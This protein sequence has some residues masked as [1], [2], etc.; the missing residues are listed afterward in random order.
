M[1]LKP[2]LQLVLLLAVAA[3]AAIAYYRYRPDVGRLVGLR[4][5]PASALAER[6]KAEFVHAWNGF[7]AH[8]WGHDELAPLSLAPR[9]WHDVPLLMTEVDSLDALLMLGL[10]EEAARTKTHILTALSFDEDIT[11]KVFEITIRLLGG[12]LSAHQMTGDPKLLALA[13]DLGNRLLPAFDSPTGMPYRFV[14]LKTGE[15]SGAETNPAEVGTLL[16]EFGTLGRLTGRDEFY[17]R[18]KQALV[19]LYDRRSPAT[20][21]VG[22]WISVESGEYTGTTSHVG[23]GIDSYYEYLLKCERL[24]GDADCGRMWK[25]GVAAVNRYLADEVD[26]GLWYGE[27]DMTT[28]ARTATTY[29]ALHAFF[30][31]VLA[32]G[33]DLERARRLQESGFRMW[34]LTGVEPEELDYSTMTITSESYQLRPELVESA[35]YLFH[36][37][38]DPRYQEM[39]RTVLDGLIARCRTESGYTTLRSVKTWEKGDRMHSFL[40]TETFKYLYLLFDPSAV[41][42]EAVVFNT[43]AHPL[44]R[45]W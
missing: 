38:K 6:T 22:D 28:G 10:D 27:A 45:T 16:L 23:G 25:D 18:A 9:D 26:G 33:G 8:A 7:K 14:N 21:L 41:D 30:P 35:Y 42:F 20:G 19:A 15:T 13:E 11:V 12:L 3:A 17:D 29:G 37:T 43:E 1:R 32:L 39:G 34:T 36:Y 40:L 4:P 24:F 44:R 2:R 31:A 5:E